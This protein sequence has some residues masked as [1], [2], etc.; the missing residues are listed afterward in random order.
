MTTPDRIF[1]AKAQ[2]RDPSQPALT[3]RQRQRHERIV[4]ISQYLIAEEGIHNITFRGLACALR[5]TQAALRLHF[6]D[7]EALQAEIVRRNLAS[8]PQSAEPPLQKRKRAD[9]IFTSGIPTTSE[10]RH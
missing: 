8:Q 2:L 10:T 5:M 7:M 1:R 6:V 9:W 4:D 3:G